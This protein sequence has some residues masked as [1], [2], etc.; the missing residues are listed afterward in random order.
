MVLAQ[1]GSCNRVDVQLAGEG[2]QSILYC[3]GH[4]ARAGQH[5]RKGAAVR[6]QSI[7]FERQVPFRRTAKPEGSGRDMVGCRGQDDSTDGDG[8]LDLMLVRFFEVMLLTH[9]TYAKWS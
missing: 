4:E 5:A 1:A 9:T 2:Q 3:S 7:S 6:P 8:S